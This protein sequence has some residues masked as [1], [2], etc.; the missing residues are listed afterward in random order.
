M[1]PNYQRVREIILKTGKG[2]CFGDEE[3]VQGTLVLSNI[4]IYLQI[5]DEKKMNE[6]LLKDIS[7]ISIGGINILRCELNNGSR[8]NFIVNNI[9]SWYRATKKAIKD[10]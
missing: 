5:D 9:F 7:N 3:T 6:I 1:Q 2:H 4:R 8:Y 10:L